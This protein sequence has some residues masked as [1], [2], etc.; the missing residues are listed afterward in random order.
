LNAFHLAH[1]SYRH[2]PPAFIA[3]HT[4]ITV[5]LDIDFGV[6]RQPAGLTVIRWS[7]RGSSSWVTP[8]DYNKIYAKIR[9]WWRIISDS[10]CVC[11]SVSVRLLLIHTQSVIQPVSHINST[12]LAD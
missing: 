6:F 12:E 4:H 1:L 7:V 8:L 10:N 9:C 11:D 3:G 2:I 5:V